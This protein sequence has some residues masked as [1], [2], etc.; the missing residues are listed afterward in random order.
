MNFITTVLSTSLV[1]ASLI[2]MAG[3]LLRS[4]I[5][6]R[7]KN[8]IRHEYERDIEAYK[9]VL[10][11]VHAATAEGQKATIDA[12]LKAFD[13]LWRAMLALRNSTGTVLLF[14]DILTVDEYR[15]LKDRTDFRAIAGRLDDQKILDMMPDK[16]IEEARPYVGEIAW[17]YFHVYQAFNLRLITMA[18]HSM[19]DPSK[20]EWHKDKPTRGLLSS[21]LSGEQMSAMDSATIGKITYVR[22]AIEA[23]VLYQWQSLLS[24]KEFGDEAMKHV[25]SRLSAVAKL[26]L[27]P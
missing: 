15:V 6:E 24:G 13:R 14:F 4:W 12:R 25:Q 8:A 20:I 5:A 18:M 17:S 23:E 2:A 3:W 1:T 21:V 27:R 16:G 11:Y 19:T 7:L 22:Q 9:S 26:R 10:S